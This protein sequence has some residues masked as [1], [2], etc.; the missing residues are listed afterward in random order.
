MLIE[1]ND[2]VEIT[3]YINAR[4]PRAEYYLLHYE[5]E[6]KRYEQGKA[7]FLNTVPSVD[8]NVGGGRPNLPGAPTERKVLQSM[9]YDEIHEAYYWLKA[10]E[11]SWKGLSDRKKLF[12]D[13]RR[14]AEKEQGSRWVTFTQMHYLE[15]L[16]KRYIIRDAWISDETI[17]RW[18]Y[19]IVRRTVEI[20]FALKIKNK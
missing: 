6:L 16:E 11:I 12:L 1:K 4:R 20:Y 2:D 15:E 5:A 10:V 14:Q 18:W 13:I 3:D 7:E 19:G 8:D 17:R 9:G